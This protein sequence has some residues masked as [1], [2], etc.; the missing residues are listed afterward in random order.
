MFLSNKPLSTTTPTSRCSTTSSSIFIEIFI[1]I[2]SIPISGVGAITSK[3]A[4]LLAVKANLVGS[5]SVRWSRRLTPRYM[6]ERGPHPILRFQLITLC[7]FT[8]PVVVIFFEIIQ[9]RNRFFIKV[10]EDVVVVDSV[11][12]RHLRF[13]CRELELHPIYFLYIIISQLVGDF[14]VCFENV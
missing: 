12:F 9:I 10:F 11:R 7:L 5:T 3:M 2:L 13:N 14:F 4:R 6:K 8:I 1:I